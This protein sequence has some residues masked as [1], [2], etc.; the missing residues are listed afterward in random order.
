MTSRCLDIRCSTPSH[1]DVSILG[2][3]ISDKRLLAFHVLLLSVWIS[4]KTLLVFDSLPLG[5]WISGETILSV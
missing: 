2:V 4:D 3:W 5:V 1:V